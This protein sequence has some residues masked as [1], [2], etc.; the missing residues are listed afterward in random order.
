MID[1]PISVDL[2]CDLGPDGGA[3]C[4]PAGDG[5][6]PGGG[7]PRGDRDGRSAASAIEGRAA[8]FIDQ[9]G[10]MTSTTNRATGRAPR[11]GR[12]AI[13]TT[14]VLLAATRASFAGSFVGP[15]TGSVAGNT[16]SVDT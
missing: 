15:L 11:V 14:L 9:G 12:L 3:A 5:T 8:P 13:L 1:F 6:R 2:E 4:A 7:D 10:T 16:Y